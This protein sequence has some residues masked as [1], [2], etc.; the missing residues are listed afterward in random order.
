MMSYSSKR[1]HKIISLFIKVII[2]LLSSGYIINKIICSKSAVDIP[3]V[4]FD[5]GYGYLIFVLLLVIA[6][7]GIEALKW[8]YLVRKIESVSFFKSFKSV[9]CGV[10][11]G[12]FTPN[13]I[14]EFAGR[15]FYLIKADKIKATLISFLGSFIQLF[16]TLILGILSCIIIMQK[17]DN[18]K[19][20][21]ME[22]LS[23]KNILLVI[24]I[25][26]I[27]GI[28]L[29]FYKEQIK[30][31]YKKYWETIFMYS[32]KE[33]AYIFILSFM[34]YMIFTFQYYLVLKMFA[35][36]V[37]ILNSFLLIALTFLVSSIIPT[38]ALTEV[39]VRGGV[40]VYFFSMYTTDH[41][42]I[43]LSS[44]IIWVINLALPA[45][46]GSLFIWKLKFFE[47]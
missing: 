4:N 17:N 20:A 45:V 27:I 32:W 47:D 26:L 23:V 10:T 31:R 24:A 43:V 28:I 36:D 19:N 41:A 1:S 25:A 18:I 3:D 12:I 40:A 34:R 38:F 22:L 35:V 5:F 37:G 9:L 16:V 46:V 29:M 15:V 11:I 44:L 21:V 42:V 2:L 39:V 14:G 7:W 6:N 33:L 30:S 13:R 8:K